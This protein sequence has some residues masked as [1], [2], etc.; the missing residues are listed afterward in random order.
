M[1]NTVSSLKRIGITERRT[2]I[3]RARRSRIKGAIK[4]LRKFLAEKNVSEATKQLTEVFSIVD[5][6]AKW[7]VI[8]K[9]TAARYKSRL[10]RRIKAL[11]A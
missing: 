5:R 11:A 8:K 7:G 3:N 4:V 6:G 2:A 10:S 9:N 1:A